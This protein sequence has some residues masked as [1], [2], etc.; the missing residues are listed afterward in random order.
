LLQWRAFAPA[1]GVRWHFFVPS[2]VCVRL[3]L[4]HVNRDYSVHSL[5]LSRFC[6]CPS[7]NYNLPILSSHSLVVDSP[8][9]FTW[10]RLYDSLEWMEWYY[11]GTRHVRTSSAHLISLDTLGV[12]LPILQHDN[13]VAETPEASVRAGA[14]VTSRSLYLFF[15]VFF[16]VQVVSFPP[17]AAL[18]H[19]FAVS[20]PLVAATGNP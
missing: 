3:P 12:L 20:N 18:A 8:L 10:R 15:G 16:L 6:G 13:L 17:N 11:S 2:A 9:V 7:G 1:A 19:S 4:E 5:L 14:I